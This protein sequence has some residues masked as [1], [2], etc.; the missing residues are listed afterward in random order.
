MVVSCPI[1]TNRIIMMLA[2]SCAVHRLMCSGWVFAQQFD[3]VNLIVIP[4]LVIEPDT[5]PK[6]VT[7][8]HLCPY[9]KISVSEIVF[10]ISIDNA[11]QI[12]HPVD[13]DRKSV[14]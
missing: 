9:V 3:N 6:T 7:F 10:C 4:G 2:A 12:T 1:R 8:G 13:L 11:C 5:A 14:V